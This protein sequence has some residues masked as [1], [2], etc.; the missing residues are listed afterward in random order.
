ML[1]LFIL[2]DP[3]PELSLEGGSITYSNDPNM[4]GNFSNGT[5]A[6]FVC[7][8]NGDGLVGAAMLFCFQGLWNKM[9]PPPTPTCEREFQLL[10]PECML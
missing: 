4:F 1:Y 7:T 8:A 10:D 9:T 2:T 5:S 6:L 3:C